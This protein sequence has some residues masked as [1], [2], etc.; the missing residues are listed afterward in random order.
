MPMAARGLAKLSE[1][2]GETAIEIG[3]LQQTIGKRLAYF[4]TAE[5]PDGAGLLTD[6]L[7]DEAADVQAAIEFISEEWGF[8]RERFDARK[9]RKLALFRQ[10]HAEVGNNEHG[11]DRPASSVP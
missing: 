5:H 2:L 8:D 3:R 11:V 10:W 6:R 9:A 1:E 7:Q 4:H